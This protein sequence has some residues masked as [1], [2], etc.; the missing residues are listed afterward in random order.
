MKKWERIE[1]ETKHLKYD[2]SIALKVK[3]IIGVTM[4]LYT[5]MVKHRNNFL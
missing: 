1:R 3:Q 4:S 2:P 5:G